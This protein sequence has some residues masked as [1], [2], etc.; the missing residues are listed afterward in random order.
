MQFS[1]ELRCGCELHRSRHQQRYMTAYLITSQQCLKPDSVSVHL[2]VRIN[3][4]KCRVKQH[5]LTTVVYP[6]CVK[7][8]L[9]FGIIY[10]PI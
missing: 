1:G 6:M 7:W 3:T 10:C 5:R 8:V 9:H 4:L 2:V